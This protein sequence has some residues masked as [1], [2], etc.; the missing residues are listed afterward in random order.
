M[1]DV[2]SAEVLMFLRDVVWA[3]Y[4]VRSTFGLC[5]IVVGKA[6]G[7]HELGSRRAGC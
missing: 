5:R 2:G 1:E 3:D 6:Q 4:P 7:L